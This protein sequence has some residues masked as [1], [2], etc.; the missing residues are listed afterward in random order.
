MTCNLFKIKYLLLLAIISSLV[1]TWQLRLFLPSRKLKMESPKTIC[2]NCSND[3]SSHPKMINKLDVQLPTVCQ[4][5]DCKAAYLKHLPLASSSHRTD[6][7]PI[8]PIRHLLWINESVSAYFAEQL[9]TWRRVHPDWTVVLWRDQ[10]LDPFV[11]KHFP[12]ALPRFMELASHTI[13]QVDMVRYMLLFKY[14]GVYADLDYSLIASLDDHRRFYAVVTREPEAHSLQYFKFQWPP[15]ILANPAF[16]MAAPGHSF[17]RHCINE[18]RTVPFARG[19]PLSFAGPFGL[20][21]ILERYNAAFPV[22]NSP[23]ETVYIPPSYSFYPYEGNKLNTSNSAYLPLRLHSLRNSCK[24]VNRTWPERLQK[25]CTDPNNMDPVTDKTQ[26][27]IA[28]HDLKKI[29]AVYGGVGTSLYFQNL[30]HLRKMF[31]SKLQIGVE[32]I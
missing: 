7:H 6:G 10:D 18:L 13:M 27:V 11:K 5:L 14:G 15:I 22:A 17:Y 2:E 29:G 16:L 25:Y 9:K 20:T 28:V 12:E 1:F 26:P 8:P 24:R 23:L 31:G 21:E 3:T 32:W 30:T 4:D 19:R